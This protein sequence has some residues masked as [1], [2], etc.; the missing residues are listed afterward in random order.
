MQED[1]G[2]ISRATL[3]KKVEFVGGEGKVWHR[4]REEV[5]FSLPFSVII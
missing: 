4:G 3:G 1:K 5:Y 2:K